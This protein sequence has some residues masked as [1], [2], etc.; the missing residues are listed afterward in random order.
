MVIGNTTIVRDTQEH[1][2]YEWNFYI[3]PV[4]GDPPLSEHIKQIVV[5]LH[6]T[7]NP[8]VRKF[9][10]KG[11]RQVELGCVGWGTFR[12]NVEIVWKKGYNEDQ[13]ELYHDLR[14]VPVHERVV[15]TSLTLKK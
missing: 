10:M 7:F 4:E 15:H 1:N 2:K 6:E 14:F 8:P 5:R 13:T 11:D 3:K 12:I 9:T